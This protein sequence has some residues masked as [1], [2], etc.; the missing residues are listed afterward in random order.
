VG[1]LS[2][3]ERYRDETSLWYALLACH[4]RFVKELGGRYEGAMRAFLGV[5]REL[6]QSTI[7]SLMNV[8]VKSGQRVILDVMMDREWLPSEAVVRKHYLS[9]WSRQ[10]RR[11]VLD[12]CIAS[13]EAMR[14]KRAMEEGRPEAAPSRREQPGL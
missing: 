4:D 8:A 6:D 9:F 3:C 7:D 11:T 14:L 13:I 1:I 2:V 12:D 10:D 5:P